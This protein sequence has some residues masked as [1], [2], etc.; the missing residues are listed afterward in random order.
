MDSQ[1]RLKAAKILLVNLSGIGTEV[2]KNIILSGIGSL[3]IL[4]SHT[5]TEDDLSCQFFVSHEEVGMKRLDAAKP[6]IKEMNSR[7][8]LTFDTDVIS[9]KTEE[10]YEQFDLVVG[11]ELK[12]SEILQINRFTRKNKIPFYATGLHGLFGYIFADLIEFDSIDKKIKGLAPTKTGVISP[13]R[14]I[15]KIQEDFDEEKKIFYEIITTRNKYKL[16]KDILDQESL[17][18]QLTRRQ[19][20][21]LTGLISLVLSL[22]SPDVNIESLDFN[23]LKLLALKKCH[24]LNLPKEYLTDNYIEQFTHQIGIEF[25][26]VCSVIGSTV[27]QDVIN[28]MGKRQSPLNNFILFDGLTLDMP[29]LEL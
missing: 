1:A 7:V 15:I 27:A 26:P 23:S 20:K 10:F 14:E 17:S 24:Q 29:I 2:A 16:F 13:N 3:V 28:V 9:T 12:N 25:A 8:E 5:L 19:A 4:D 18:K 11:T 22:L 6:R 21:Q